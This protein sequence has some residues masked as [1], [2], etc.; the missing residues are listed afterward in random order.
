MLVH[1]FGE[2]TRVI[3]GATGENSVSF[4]FDNVPLPLPEVFDLP[5]TGNW[6]QG[7]IGNG[8]FLTRDNNNGPNDVP[9]ISYGTNATQVHLFQA[10]DGDT[11]GDRT[12]DGQDIQAILSANSFGNPGG[13]P[14]DWPQG[15]F[16]GDQVVDGSDISAILAT[17][18]WGTPQPYD[19][20]KAVDPG[21]ST[22]DVVDLILDVRDNSLA[23]DTG[24]VT[25]NGY[26]IRSAAGIFTG[27]PAENLGWFPEDTDRQISGNFILEPPLS[28]EHR[29]GA[30]IGPEWEIIGKPPVDPYD[31]LTFT[32]TVYGE[33]VT[34]YGNL[35]II[36][37]PGTV[38]MLLGGVAGLWLLSLG[39]RR[40]SS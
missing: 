30:V 29:L 16:N 38:I 7:H 5:G 28:G 32:Y 14:Y 2:Q 21:D 3:A 40:R 34:R 20:A 31:D 8:A 17:G 26:V 22:D 13:G 11:N 12:L 10:A 18:L 24:N 4:A 15:D 23:L 35:I 33:P 6:G 27:A 36:P 39:R 1:W 9:G 25:I 19:G 37:E